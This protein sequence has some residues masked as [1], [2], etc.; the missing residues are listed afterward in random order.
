MAGVFTTRS[1][2]NPRFCRTWCARCTRR[3]R[4]LRFWPGLCP[5]WW[6]DWFD[7]TQFFI[8]LFVFFSFFFKHFVEEYVAPALPRKHWD[9]ACWNCSGTRPP[10]SPKHLHNLFWQKAMYSQSIVTCYFPRLFLRIFSYLISPTPHTRGQRIAACAYL[11]KTDI[12]D[13]IT[14]L[15]LLVCAHF[16]MHK[17]SDAEKRSYVFTHVK[18]CDLPFLCT[19]SRLW[20]CVLLRGFRF[21]C[22]PCPGN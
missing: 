15:T 13:V 7:W 5:P 18:T 11:T 12:N 20:Y 4:M 2:A 9:I 19:F 1:E 16:C 3:V 21:S 8:W 6:V 17:T 14:R 10:P 22:S